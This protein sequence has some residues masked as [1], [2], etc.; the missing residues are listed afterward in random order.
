MSPYL[1]ILCM[2]VLGALIEEKC[3]AKFWNSVK[4][5]QDGPE[6]SHI[7]FADDVLGSQAEKPK[8]T[9]LLAKLNWRF[10]SEKSSL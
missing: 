1:F 7:F 2:E 10:N 8:N 5:S 9:A 4:A 3:K 6:V